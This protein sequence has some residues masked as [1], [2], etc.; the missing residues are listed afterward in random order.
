MGPPSLALQP[1]A[2]S[3]LLLEMSIRY[4][5]VPKS[6]V[7]LSSVLYRRKLVNCLGLTPRLRTVRK[8][9]PVCV[10]RL[11]SLVTCLPM[12]GVTTFRLTVPSTP[13]RL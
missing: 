2:I 6:A 5:N 1:S 7:L 11:L 8:L 10:P 3:I 12:F 9:Q 13:P 4:M